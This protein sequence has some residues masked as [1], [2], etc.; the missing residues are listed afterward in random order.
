M[1]RVRIGSAVSLSAIAAIFVLGTAY[2]AFGLVGVDWSREYTTASIDLPDAV[3]L[4]PRSPVLL[5]GIRVGEVTTVDS[6]P[7]GVSIIVQL[8]STYRIPLNS[9][10][11]IEQLSALGEPYINF[12]P[13]TSVGPYLDNGQRFTAEDVTVPVSVPDLSRAVTTLL[14]QI[15]PQTIRSIVNT[16]SEGLA[17]TEEVVPQLARASN[18]LAATLQS[19]EPQLRAI[20][21][22]AQVP[23]PDVAQAGADLIAA[24]PQWA[25][26]GGKSREVIDSLQVLLHARP[27][28]DAYT[29]NNGLLD[30]LPKVKEYLNRVGP[31]L[32]QLY[33]ALENWL[34]WAIGEVPGSINLSELIDQALHST[35]PNGSLQLQINTR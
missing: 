2:L 20:L 14:E 33:P 1:K 35:G 21:K 31:E 29:T 27:V 13:R 30:F 22:N 7:T 28:P 23:G 24:A 25:A 8:D 15:D 16:F 18:L 26:F 9:A 34:D 11:S 6:T 5:S 4:L 17:D 32:V 19:R 10:I 3:N 12:R